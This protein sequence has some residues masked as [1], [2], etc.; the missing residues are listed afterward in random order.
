[1]DNDGRPSLEAVRSPTPSLQSGWLWVNVMAAAALVAVVGCLGLLAQQLG[2]SWQSAWPAYNDYF[3]SSDSGFAWG[4]WFLGDMSEPTFYKHELAS[5][6]LCI[7]AFFAWLAAYR[8]SR[9]QGFPIAY[10]SGLWPWILAASTFSLLLNQLLWGWTL[11]NTANWQPTFVVFVSLPAATV[12]LL[13]RG[14]RVAMLGAVMGP[15]L[16]TPLALLLINYLCIPM[17][18]PAVIG[19]VSAMALGSVAAFYLYRVFRGAI[20]VWV[21]LPVKPQ[22]MLVEQGTRR[23][24]RFGAGWTVRR[25]LADFS[26]SQFYGNEWAGIGLIAGVLLAVV[27]N[28]LGPAYGSLL[29]P[30]ILVGQVMTS[31]IGII[32]WRRKWMEKGWY[33]TYVPVVSVVPACVVGLGSAPEVIILS[34]FAG[35]LIGPPLASWISGQLPDDF[36]PY[37]GNMLS[38]ALSTLAIILWLRWVLGM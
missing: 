29:L 6:G 16:V 4:R 25:I 23:E 19:G 12:L 38:M 27:L 18:W 15:L 20:A 13:G 14:W 2:Q 28:P 34:A 22:E 35:A 30:Q 31:A 24:A 1:M 33:P 3:S 17:G 21:R 10:G 5:L 37:I 36:H 11:T 8:G 26:E 32:L 9:W 7:G